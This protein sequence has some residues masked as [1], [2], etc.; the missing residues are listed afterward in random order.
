MS[1]STPEDTYSWVHFKVRKAYSLHSDRDSIAY[2]RIDNMI[3]TNGNETLFECF[4]RLSISL[5][6]TNTKHVFIYV[7]DTIFKKLDIMLPFF[8]FQIACLNQIN[9]API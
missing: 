9:V 1:D 5:R 6:N 3:S 2:F 7:Y 4:P 8:D